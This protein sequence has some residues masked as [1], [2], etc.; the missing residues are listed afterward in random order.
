[1]LGYVQA[2]AHGPGPN[3]YAETER[4]YATGAFLMAASQLVKLA[5]LNLPPAPN[6]TAAVKPPPEAKVK[7]EVP[8]KNEEAGAA[9]QSA[10]T[11]QNP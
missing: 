9:D 4:T 1:M 5:P 2:V 6:L 11:N 10:V 8:P 7:N 3:V